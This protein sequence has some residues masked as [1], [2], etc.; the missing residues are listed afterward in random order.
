MTTTY[1][2]DHDSRTD[3][4]RPYVIQRS[5]GNEAPDTYN[6]TLQTLV[7]G[8]NSVVVLSNTGTICQDGR[9][10]T[11][12]KRVAQLNRQF[13]GIACFAFDDKSGLVTCVELGK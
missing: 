13:D 12:R 3:G 10:R 7:D 8:L 4:S 9:A 6:P 5:S 2:F 11:L 1:A